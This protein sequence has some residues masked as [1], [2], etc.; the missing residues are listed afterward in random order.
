M[1]KRLALVT[2]A[3]RG[4][5]A[6]IVARLIVDGVTVL[7]ADLPESQHPDSD[8]NRIDVPLDVTEPSSIATMVKFVTERFGK[9]D[10]LVNNAGVFSRTPLSALA[11]ETKERSIF[12]VNA[13]GSRRMVEAFAT[14]LRQGKQPA[15]VNVASVRGFTASEHAAAY[16]ISK[17]MVIDL[18]R[19]VARDLT[20]ILCNAVAPGDIATSMSPLEPEI[21]AKLMA[22]IPLGRMGHPSEVANAVAF[23]A[24]DRAQGINGVV[25]PVDGGFL[26]T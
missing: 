13:L 21:L 12:A 20:P 1:V 16:S 26:C 25:L 9:L 2:G 22:R 6:A 5:G 3:A 4:I 24:S 11:M 10:A 8:P 14:L 18:T 7:A 17:A 23:L 19:N 15:I